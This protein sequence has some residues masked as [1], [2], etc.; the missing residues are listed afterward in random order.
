MSALKSTLFNS[1]PPDARA[2]ISAHYSSL[3]KKSVEAIRRNPLKA[4]SRSKA[5]IVTR[6]KDILHK[7]GVEIPRQ[8]RDYQQPTTEEAVASESQLKDSIPVARTA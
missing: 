5:G 6:Y 7:A 2:A 1:L 8:L 3:G 4:K